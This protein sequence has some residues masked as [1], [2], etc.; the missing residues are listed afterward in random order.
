VAPRNPL[1][2]TLVQ[3]WAEVLELERVG[4]HDNFFDLGGHSLQ[5]VQLVARL[6]AALNRPVSVKMVFLAPTAAAMAE[7]LEREAAAAGSGDQSPRD[8]GAQP[9]LA[10]WLL[11]SKPAV[12]PE[13]V[14]IERRP[15]RSLLA[16]AELAPV[17]SVAL[18]YLP[19]AALHL[20]GVDRR[21][22][23]HDWCGDRPFLTDVRE[24]P[25][26]RIGSVLIPRFDDELYQDPRDL[27]AVLADA[28]GFAGEIGAAT[29]SLTGLLP[30]ATGYGRDLAAALSGLD[31]P[32]ITTGH[33]TTTS[34][35]V[36][37]I[38]RALE[39][40][41]RALSGE[42]LG[43]IGA[44]SVGVATLRL[45][46]SCLPHPARLSLCDVYSKQESLESLQRELKAEL[47]Y[48]GQVRL[49][50]SRHEVPAELYEATLIVGATN[51]AD[52]LDISGLAPGTIVVDDSAP[53]AF[54]QDEAMRRFRDQG[55]ILVTEGGVLLAPEP[56]PLCVYVPDEL[57]PWLA[58]GLVSLVARSNPQYITGCVLS[59][60]LSARFAHL[61]PTIG[62]IDRQ[63]AL[64]HYVTLESLGF[65]AANLHVDDE[66]LD[67]A[68]ISRFRS[69]YGTPE[70]PDHGGGN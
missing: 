28:V 65:R 57:E 48:R 41:G 1:E 64:E 33:A 56:L 43:L 53:H 22:V 67:A 50:A 55:D 9:A 25:L 3:V 27:V 6:T 13:H 47:G 17:D 69:R 4:V 30:S 60:L 10:R 20:A 63:T 54:R 15:F 31:R 32:R 68:I 23:I 42:H 40:G 35:V 37:S 18:G 11:E 12:L 24:T 52:I 58:A 34:A 61:A 45:L 19:S 14:T 51:V 70:L 66:P 46:L 49:L 62:F 8:D 2:A 44:G 26:G 59:G 36:L 7:L 21:T 38:R 29:V 5:S 16:A 39:E